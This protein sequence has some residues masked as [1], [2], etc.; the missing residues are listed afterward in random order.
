MKLIVALVQIDDADPVVRALTAERISA[1][2]IEA[3]GGFLREGVAAILIGLDDGRVRHA[4]TLLDRHCQTRRAI[5]PEHFPA[6]P[7][8]WPLAE[9]AT[10]E[11]GGTTAFVLPVA[12]FE[13]F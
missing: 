2:I 4:L 10:V 12:R 9:V 13:R 7:R 5:L 3:R 1:T 8:D 6:T 11:I